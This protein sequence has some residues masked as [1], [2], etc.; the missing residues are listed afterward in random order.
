MFGSIGDFQ[1][2]PVFEAQERVRVMEVCVLCVDCLNMILQ[3]IA[4]ITAE[5]YITFPLG[6]VFMVWHPRSI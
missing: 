6:E 4:L 5:T 2:K 1:G 3:G